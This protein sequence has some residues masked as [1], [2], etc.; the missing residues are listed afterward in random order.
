MSAMKKTRTAKNEKKLELSTQAIRLLRPTRLEQVAGGMLCEA[1]TSG[2]N[3]PGD[4]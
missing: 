3:K 1:G 4:I 2:S